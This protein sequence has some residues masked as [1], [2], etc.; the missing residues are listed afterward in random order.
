M[1]SPGAKKLPCRTAG[2][3]KQG[4]S[5]GLRANWESRVSLMEEM[6]PSPLSSMYLVF[7]ALAKSL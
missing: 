6:E 5:A 7:P 4:R 2:G 3:A 1:D